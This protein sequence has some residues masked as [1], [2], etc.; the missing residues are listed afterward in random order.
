MNNAYAESRKRGILY[1]AEQRKKR[2]TAPPSAVPAEATHPPSN[3]VVGLKKS[4]LI[5]FILRRHPQETSVDRL[6]REYLRTSQDMTVKNLKI[7]LGKK[8]SYFPYSQFQIMTLADDNVVILPNDMTLAMVRR[9]ICDKP[10]DEI[11]FYYR[12]FSQY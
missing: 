5:E 2:T 4:P 11:I 8:L 7:F 6:K 3:R 9:D 1:Q 12:I 10:M